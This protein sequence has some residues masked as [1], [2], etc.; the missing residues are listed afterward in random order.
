MSR[1]DG[2][3]FTGEALRAALAKTWSDAPGLLG[4][5]TTI[6]HKRIGRRYIATAFVFLALAGVLALVMRVQLATPESG[7]IS[8]D[9]YNQIFT[10]HG[11][12][13]MFLFA[14]PVM[15]AM[16]IYL[17]PLML[18]T[19]SIAFPR[20]NAFSYYTYLAGG[21]MVWIAFILNVGPDAGW[22]S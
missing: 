15:E 21:V 9:R 4:W 19:R 20:L 6:D 5:L 3:Q 7:L 18:G 14:V 16:A 17:I 2:P 10:M 11:T 13:M 22:F 8:A 12:T 1:V